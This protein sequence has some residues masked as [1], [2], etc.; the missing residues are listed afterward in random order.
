[1]KIKLLVDGTILPRFAPYMQPFS[2]FCKANERLP[3]MQA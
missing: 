3:V 1:M 2:V